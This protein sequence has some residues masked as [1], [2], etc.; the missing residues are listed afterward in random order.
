MKKRILVLGCTGSIGS[1]TLDIARNM[2]SEFEVCGVA[3]GTSAEKVSQLCAE[4]GCDGTVFER[5]GIDGIRKLIQNCGADIAV[6]GIAGAAGL[7]P[8]AL[9]LENGT[10]LALAN[11]ETVVMAWPVI[12]KL[13]EKNGSRIIPVDSEHS[14]LFSLLQKI[15]KEQA[16]ELILTASGGPFREFPDSRLETV[17]VQD[18][19]AHPTWS[20][21]PKITV[22][23][24]TL[25]NKGLEVIEA[26]RLFDVPAEK[27]KV[28]VHPQSLI[29]SLV[30]TADGMMYAQISCPDMRHPILSALTWPEC[31]KSFLEPFDLASCGGMTFFPPRLGSFPLLKAAFSCAEKGG[32]YAVAFNAANEV[33]VH[34]FLKEQCR[35]TDIADI[36]LKTLEHGWSALPCTLEDVHEADEAARNEAQKHLPC[37]AG[38]RA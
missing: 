27:V 14:A 11:K 18:A 22:D 38:G 6:N 12:Q 13:A 30:R 24:A 15:G 34:A 8:S 7:E 35:F 31:R 21:G 37:R 5:D 4:F 23:S 25:A 29:H 10:D 9:V 17:T 33:A 36:V 2:R 20:M 28:V 19:L 16:S 3:A 1:Q 26:C 32:S